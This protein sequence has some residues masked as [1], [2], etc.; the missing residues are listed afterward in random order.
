MPNL[1]HCLVGCRHLLW[2]CCVE[3]R[4]HYIRET[5]QYPPELRTHRYGF[6]VAW[7]DVAA[8]QNG[9]PASN[10]FCEQVNLLFSLSQVVLLRFKS[11]GKPP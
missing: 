9:Y 4:L 11:K 3:G 10:I 5:A 7:P 6:P 1:L 2:V 8:T